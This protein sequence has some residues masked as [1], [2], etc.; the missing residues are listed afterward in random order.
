M[1]FKMHFGIQNA[2]IHFGGD[3]WDWRIIR[4]IQVSVIKD[5]IFNKA[6]F[7]KIDVCTTF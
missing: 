6:L 3:L 5:H 2:Y 4:E 7:I 1:M